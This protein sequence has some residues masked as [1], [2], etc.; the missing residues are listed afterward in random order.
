MLLRALDS[1]GMSDGELAALPERTLLALTGALQA[2]A[3]HEGKDRRGR[4]I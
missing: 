1:A 2:Q 4:R 3:K